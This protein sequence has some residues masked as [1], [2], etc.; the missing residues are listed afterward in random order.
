MEPSLA[1]KIYYSLKDRFSPEMQ[2]YIESTFAES[3]HERS[4]A[5]RIPAEAAPLFGL[6]LNVHYWHNIVPPF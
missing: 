1:K 4:V 5:Q 3:S 6:L 2:V